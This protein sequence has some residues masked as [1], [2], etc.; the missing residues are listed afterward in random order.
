MSRLRIFGGLLAIGGLVL[1]FAPT[2]VHDP[3]PA[4]DSFAA[5]ERRIQ[6]GAVLG[7]GLLLVFRTRVEPWA[8]TVAA[9]VLWMVVGVLI[10][11]VAGLALDGADSGKQWMWVGVEAVVAGI[12]GAY[13]W[14]KSKRVG[15]EGAGSREV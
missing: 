8:S 9:F 15:S 4:P 11:R 12:A 6:W 7:F 13:L 1:I 2:L 14:Y 5:I 3:G 10:A